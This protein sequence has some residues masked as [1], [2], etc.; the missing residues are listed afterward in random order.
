MR[1]PRRVAAAL[2]TVGLAAVVVVGL[3]TAEPRSPDRVRALASRLRCPTC[4][5]ESVADS[6]AAISADI[7]QQI[8]EQVAA[9]K[10][11]DEI[12]DFFT[13][14]YGDEILLDPPVGGRTWLVWALPPV[15]L[16]VGLVA[17]V[18]R[19]RR[20]PPAEPGP[21]PVAAPAPRS[22][23][24]ALVGAGL[25]LAAGGLVAFLVAQAVEPRPEGGFVTG[26][27]AASAGEG[28]VDLSTVSDEELEEVVA[29]NPGVVRMRL[30][31]AKRYVEGE[32]FAQAYD[33][34]QVVLASKPTGAN[35]QQAL[36]VLGWATVNLGRP[37]EGATLL[38]Q[39]LALDPT[40]PNVLFFLGITRLR[41]GDD[42]A[43]AAVLLQR[44]LDQGTRLGDE[45]R[46]LI[47]VAL[48]QAR[49][50]GAASTS[51]ST[52]EAR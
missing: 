32:Q 47:E 7:R 29:Q 49:R 2:V 40:D 15:A 28:G 41:Y 8:A 20:A 35:R 52:T 6:P 13:T 31:L 27:V 22:R 17:M 11:D 18:A 9:G 4:D 34:A 33:H 46:R 45:E 44:L 3:L 19:R 36:F 38:E 1:S 12:V 43:G 42:P 14:R 26:G 23:R 50:G 51:T 5:S 21:D 30:A 48:A 16:V 37:D 39:S 24:R 25:L 10:S